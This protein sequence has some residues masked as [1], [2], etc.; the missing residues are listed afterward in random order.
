[1]KMVLNARIL[2]ED[3]KEK[4][5]ILPTIEDITDEELRSVENGGAPENEHEKR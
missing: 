4:T 5:G 2:R 1:M 3:S